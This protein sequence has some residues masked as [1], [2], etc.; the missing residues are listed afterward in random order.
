MEIKAA[1]GPVPRAAITGAA[2]D[3]SAG[4]KAHLPSC[5]ILKGPRSIP[6]G[7]QA[8]G[9]GSGGRHGTMRTHVLGDR[10]LLGSNVDTS[11][12]TDSSIVLL[13]LWLICF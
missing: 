13:L 4:C 5:L 12:G 10:Q 3:F 1:D 7:M 2:I 6:G 8:K 9:S 11:W